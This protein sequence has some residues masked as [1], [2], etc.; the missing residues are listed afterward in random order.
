[1]AFRKPTV[2]K[3]NIREGING[4]PLNIIDAHESNG[5]WNI[6]YE[7]VVGIYGDEVQYIV[8]ENTNLLDFFGEYKSKILKTSHPMRMI[9]NTT[10]DTNL[11][12]K[13]TQFM[14]NLGIVA[15][16]DIVAHVP[17]KT[18]DGLGFIPKI[19]DSIYIERTNNLYRIEF[20]DHKPVDKFQGQDIAYELKMSLYTV[21]ANTTIEDDVK[22]NIN[23]IDFIETINDEIKSLNN[24]KI[25][26]KIEEQSII[27]DS[28]VNGRI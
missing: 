19:N 11:D 3:A 15:S 9:I 28:E 16:Q 13:T 27:N 6:I 12:A 1:M 14:T 2:D 24:D 20:V 10:F 8:V 17:K 22:D 5:L 7:D 25:D 26:S 23:D 4:N 18:F 21:N